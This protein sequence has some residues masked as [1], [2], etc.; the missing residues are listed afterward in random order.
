MDG[1][2]FSPLR[3]VSFPIVCS[4]QACLSSVQC[5]PFS[6]WN[7]SWVTV[8]GF[9]SLCAA[10]CTGPALRWDNKSPHALFSSGGHH[11]LYHLNNKT[12]LQTFTVDFEFEQDKYILLSNQGFKFHHFMDQRMR[13]YWNLS[14]LNCHAFFEGNIMSLSSWVFLSCF[15]H[16][17][18]LITF[19]SPPQI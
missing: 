2:W 8:V 18:G 11:V 4:W 9:L 1:L 19:N 16:D 17:L 12:L 10:D 6:Q 5:I 15:C 7:N 14:R 3:F 13:C